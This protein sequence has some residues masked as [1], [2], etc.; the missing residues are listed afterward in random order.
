MHQFMLGKVIYKT[1][2][3]IVFSLIFFLIIDRNLVSAQTLTSP[4]YQLIDPSIN[5]GGNALQSTASFKLF[6]TL[7]DVD[8]AKFDSSTY[9]VGGGLGNTIVM[10][11]PQITA[12]QPGAGDPGTVCGGVGNIGDPAYGC[13]DRLKVTL[14]SDGNPSDTLYAIEVT[15]A[16]DTNWINKKY[17][18]FST[19]VRDASLSTN[20]FATLSSINALTYTVGSLNANTS[21]KFRSFAIQIANS[22]SFPS[23]GTYFD[24]SPYSQVSTVSTKLPGIALDIDIAS[25]STT[26]SSAP[27]T[28]SLGALSSS[29]VTTSPTAQGIWVKIST[30]ANS[31]LTLSVN[32]SSNGLVDGAKIIGSADSSFNNTADLSTSIVGFGKVLRTG[33]NIT[34]QGVGPAGITQTIS[35][36]YNNFGTD[37]VGKLATGI[38]TLASTN[39]PN[40]LIVSGYDL[41]ARILST[42]PAGSYT[43]T[44]TYT[45]AGSF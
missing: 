31:G 30:N 11:A 37:T 45:L 24:Q 13:Y 4:T 25:D 40:T 36:N 34:N 28:V 32:D 43:D 39:K 21:Y 15:E 5:S 29:V 19:L 18:N 35:S 9:S 16:S 3:L 8:A 12:A 27:Y 6:E 44:I 17:V 14:A 1:I 7:G 41:K 2:I 20:T 22:A 26:P 42:T 10:T 33:G 38:V 23:G